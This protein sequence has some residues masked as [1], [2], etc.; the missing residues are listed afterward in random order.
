VCIIPYGVARV[1]RKVEK[2]SA[3]PGGQVVEDD[4]PKD[5]DDGRGSHASEDEFVFGLLL[6]A[7]IITH[8]PPDA[9]KILKN[10]SRRWDS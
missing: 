1:Q 10:F 3:H 7:P 2:I 9:R 5:E 4:N 6:H 8:R